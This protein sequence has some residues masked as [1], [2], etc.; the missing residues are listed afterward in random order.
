MTQGSGETGQAPRRAESG[1]PAISVQVNGPGDAHRKAI[2]PE[3]PT[4]GAP[5]PNTALTS[6]DPITD[7]ASARRAI[8]RSRDLR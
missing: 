2:R 8:G 7:P 4:A 1:L 5:P 3:P 6:S